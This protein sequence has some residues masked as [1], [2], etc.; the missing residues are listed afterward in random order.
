MN[1]K[2][3]Q[4]DY[5]KEVI[6]DDTIISKVVEQLRMMPDDLQQEVLYFTQ[7]LQVSKPAGVAGKTLIQF[8]GTIPLDDLETMRQA[9]SA[10]CEQV[11]LNEW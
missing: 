6:M 7:R 4:D 3:R 5:S 8:A 9:I 1:V 10:D 2:M 11:D